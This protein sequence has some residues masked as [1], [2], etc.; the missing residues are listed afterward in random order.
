MSKRP[1]YPLFHRA[2]PILGRDG[3][4]SKIQPSSP[5]AGHV[6]AKTGTYALYDALNKKLMVTGKG[7]AGYIDTADGRH[8]VFAAYV[9]LVDIPL[10]PD[11]VTEIPGQALGKIAAAAYDSKITQ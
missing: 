11:A 1:S 10:T 8:L 2:L 9:N 5:A 7:L 3:T 6:F 4:L